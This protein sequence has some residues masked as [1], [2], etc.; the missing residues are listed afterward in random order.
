MTPKVESPPEVR[1]MEEEEEE[2]EEEEMREEATGMLSDT[3]RLSLVSIFGFVSFL[4]SAL[5]GR[6]RSSLACFISFS[7]SYTWQNRSLNFTKHDDAGVA[8]MPFGSNRHKC[9]PKHFQHWR[10]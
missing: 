6:A 8:E 3:G 1:N 10:N 9:G 5:G 4:W 2:E 7:S